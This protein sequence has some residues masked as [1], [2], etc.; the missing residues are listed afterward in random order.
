MSRK[1][2]LIGVSAALIVCFVILFVFMGYAYGGFKQPNQVAVLSYQV[3]SQSMIEDYNK[4]LLNGEQSDI[5]AGL[6]PIIIEIEKKYDYQQDPTC[7]FMRVEY[8]LQSNDTKKAE[9]VYRNLKQL[10]DSGHSPSAKLYNLAGIELFNDKIQSYMSEPS[11]A[12]QEEAP[13]GG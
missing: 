6:K 11:K 7:E 2:L 8:Y 9:E 4:A 12:T 1:A 13:G 3:C 5:V 10:V